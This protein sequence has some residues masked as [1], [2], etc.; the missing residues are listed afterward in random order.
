[1]TA[2]ELAYRIDM[3]KKE[4]AENSMKVFT[5]PIRALRAYFHRQTDKNRLY[6]MTDRQLAD[7]GITRGDIENI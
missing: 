4:R 5:Y 3:A 1:M 7:I 2:T 6:Q